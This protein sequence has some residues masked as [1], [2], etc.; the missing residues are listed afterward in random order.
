[1][2]TFIPTTTLPNGVYT[3]PSNVQ[4]VY[5][6]ILIVHLSE[7]STLLCNFEDRNLSDFQEPPSPQQNVE[8]TGNRVEKEM[9]QE[10]RSGLCSFLNSSTLT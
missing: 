1:M 2:F 4:T 8:K 7:I 10:T 6:R 9:R 3:N 5:K